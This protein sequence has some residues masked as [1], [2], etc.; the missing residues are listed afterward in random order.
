MQGP[1]TT[2]R[3]PKIR[4]VKTFPMRNFGRK[5]GPARVVKQKR[6][7]HLI[8]Y[9]AIKRW[10]MGERAEMDEMDFKAE[11]QEEAKKEMLIT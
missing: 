2:V 11:V 8:V 6:E 5:R 4:N 9:Q 3:M 10:P 1:A 7:R